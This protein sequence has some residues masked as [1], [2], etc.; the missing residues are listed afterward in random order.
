MTVAII[1]NRRESLAALKE[2]FARKG[3]R[4]EFL[5]PGPHLR[6]DLQAHPWNLVVLDTESAPF[7]DVAKQVLE[8]D[9]NLNMAFITDK[10]TQTFHEVGEGFGF[11][12]A[13]PTSPGVLDAELLL[14]RLKAV[15]GV[16][17]A[18]EK[19]QAHLDAMSRQHHPRCVV[20]WGQHPFGLKVDYRVTGTNTVGIDSRPRI[21]DGG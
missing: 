17:P 10:D 14:T 1:T 7:R 19:A 13:L 12:G 20:C 5:A 15:G 6:Q 11:L 4:S 16:D 3:Y 9:A 2:G 21:H 18:I 8:V